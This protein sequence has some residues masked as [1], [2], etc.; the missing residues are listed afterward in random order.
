M[1]TFVSS[2]VAI[3]SIGYMK[4]DPGYWRFF[5]YISLFVFSMTMLV[6][7]SNFVLLYVCWE[8]VG[9]CSYLLIGFWFEKPEAAAAACGAAADVPKKFGNEASFSHPGIVVLSVAE[10]PRKVSFTP[11]G[12]TICGF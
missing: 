3:Y 1:V 6:S 9:V 2:L 7:A 5:A 12:P 8:A 11:S 10:N 4:D